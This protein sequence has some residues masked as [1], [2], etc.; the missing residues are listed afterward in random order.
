MSLS[1]ENMRAV[2]KKQAAMIA[3]M[4]VELA[5]KD[6]VIATKDAVLAEKDSVIAHLR[7][8]VDKMVEQKS[9]GFPSL[10]LPSHLSSSTGSFPF[11]S[12]MVTPTCH[13]GCMMCK[14]LGGVMCESC[15]GAGAYNTGDACVPCKGVG[16]YSGHCPQCRMFAEVFEGSTESGSFAPPTVT[17]TTDPECGKF[18]DFA[19]GEPA[20]A[21]EATECLAYIKAEVEV[22]KG[23]QI[24]REEKDRQMALALKKADEEAEAKKQRQIVADMKYAATLPVEEA[25]TP[26]SYAGVAAKKPAVMPT[27][28]ASA[29]IKVVGRKCKN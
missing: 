16:Y 17:P 24:A 23:M 20:K 19:Y 18:N 3:D 8:L 22:A 29:W 26:E 1:N 27:A 12:P 13:V 2:I 28:P 7:G 14:G 25:P 4:E 21:D 15:N 11:M 9:S 5:E 10:H 6:S